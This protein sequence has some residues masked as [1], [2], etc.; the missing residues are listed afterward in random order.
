[1][2]F[3]SITY[4]PPLSDYQTFTTWRSP[5]ILKYHLEVKYI[6]LYHYFTH[7]VNHLTIT[8]ILRKTWN[9]LGKIANKSPYVLVVLGDFNVKSSNWYK[10]DKTTYDVSKIIAITSQFGLQQLIKEPTHFHS[11]IF[12]YWSIIY[13]PTRP[14]NEIRS[15]FFSSSKLSSPNNICKN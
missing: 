1:M 6:T 15:S 9:C 3:V 2:V 11:F 4:T 8:K 7:L 10:H 5:W 12:M 13:F 14:R